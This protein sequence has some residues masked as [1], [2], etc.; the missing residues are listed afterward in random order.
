MNFSDN[1]AE[2]RL[3]IRQGLWDRELD[4]ADKRWLGPG[5]FSASELK[6]GGEVRL[7]LGPTSV[8]VYNLRN[9]PPTNR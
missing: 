6:G 4:S 1:P 5:C 8:I 2:V 9:D 7:T 3:M